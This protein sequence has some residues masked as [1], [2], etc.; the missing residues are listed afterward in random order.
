[1][2]RALVVLILLAAAVSVSAAGF[3]D[4]YTGPRVNLTFSFQPLG[5]FTYTTTDGPPVYSNADPMISSSAVF[6]YRFFDDVGVG[7]Y[8]EVRGYKWH[9]I[10]TTDPLFGQIYGAPGFSAGPMAFWHFLRDPLPLDLYVAAGLGLNVYITGEGVFPGFDLAVDL[11]LLYRI[12]PGLSA[13]LR[14]CLR[15]SL[16]PGGPDLANP[17][18]TLRPFQLS[19][20]NVGPAVRISF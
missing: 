9:T 1:M 8:L 16:H 15:T 5:L 17:G 3:L 12:F 7:A 13:G 11:G 4:P 14:G 10:T 18:A 2:R 6:E 19:E 20:F